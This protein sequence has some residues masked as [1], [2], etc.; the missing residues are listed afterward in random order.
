MSD[1]IPGQQEAY[2][3][4]TTPPT[5]Y[6][7]IAQDTEVD[8]IIVGGGI[9]GLTTAYLM[10]RTGKRVAVVERGRIAEDVT[11]HTT[12]KI[13]AL[14][15]LIYRHLFRH[16]DDDAV[17]LYA[18]LN[19]AAVLSIEEVVTALGVD[20]DFSRQPSFVFTEEDDNV[21]AIEQE[22][23]AA[24]RAGLPVKLVT[25]SPLPFPIKAAE[26]LD[27]QAQFHPRKY[28]LAMAGAI[29]GDGSH[30]FEQTSALMPKDKGPS[31]MTSGGVIK[32]EALVI[33]TQF[34]MR[35]NGYFFAKLFPYV[36]YALAF[37]IKGD[38]PEG[39]YFS[40]DGMH[41]GIRSQA[42]PDGSLV[43]VSGGYNRTGQAK[44]V[45][46][47]Y[48]ALETYAHERFDIT[49]L[50]DFWM[51]MD[52]DTADGMPYVGKAPGD[53]HTYLAA[54]FGGWGMTQ[55]MVAAELL[56]DLVTGQ[57]NP[58]AK[59]FDPGRLKPTPEM[60]EQG[61][62][63]SEQYAAGFERERRHGRLEDLPNGEA[64]VSE[65]DGQRLA[66]YRDGQGVLHTVSPVCTH[67]S[68]VVNWNNAELTWD[69]PCHGSRFNHDGTV[70]HGPAMGKLMKLKV[71]K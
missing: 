51:T 64:A 61:I 8:V 56:T 10:K 12:A 14:H 60:V 21:K 59:V 63:I 5:N 42:D 57:E 40:E 33:A 35:D 45:L 47:E 30:I 11:G 18:R 6:P 17:K 50:R 27:D 28:L 55:S 48:R 67:L 20:C 41:H 9:T 66:A 43:I 31:L 2:W 39:V 46:A 23:E 4:A 25:E 70:I 71:T 69:C 15:S 7:P 26:R 44:D 36:D 68:C 38:T 52:Y 54:G 65:I 22:V 13:T 53:E 29:D 49:S 24:E 58:A 3:I 32:G 34:P 37:H 1:I 62:N 16:F 19:M